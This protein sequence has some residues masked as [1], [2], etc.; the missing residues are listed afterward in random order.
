MK[1]AV[2]YCR[3]SSEDQIE[4][5]VL[6]LPTQER[7]CAQHCEHNGWPIAKIFTDAGESARTADRP[8]L[9]EV[10]KFCRDPKHKVTHVV[11]ADLSRLARNVF[12]QGSIIA[13]LTEHKIR[14]VSVDEPM[15]DNS[16]AG[17]FSTSVLGALNQF[18]SNNQSEKIKYRMRA[19]VEQGRFVNRAP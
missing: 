15:L 18:Y 6:N 9:Q 13:I 11:V 14:L 1:G 4:R 17:K 8:Q 7:K 3:V 5:N 12:D 2:L 16:A 19:A 10:L